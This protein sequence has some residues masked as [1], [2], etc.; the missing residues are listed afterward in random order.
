[1]AWLWV[2]VS[3][4]IVVFTVQYTQENMGALIFAGGEEFNEFNISVCSNGKTIYGWGNK[5]VG[6]E[7]VDYGCFN[8]EGQKIAG[9]ETAEVCRAAAC[10]LG[11]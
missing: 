10:R 2:L 6:R 7:P 9:V 1:M 3:I 8:A 5:N 4:L 11:Y